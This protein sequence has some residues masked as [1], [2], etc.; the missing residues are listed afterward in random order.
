M[1]NNSTSTQKEAKQEMLNYIKAA[2]KHVN[3]L[4]ELIRN[5]NELNEELN[6]S[7]NARD[8]LKKIDNSILS[9][10]FIKYY[11]LYKKD[12]IDNQNVEKILKI[13]SSIH[14]K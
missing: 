2:R 10:M 12:Y 3:N 13:F 5:T 9:D 14:T 7:K 1:K 11:S 4:A 8:Y 6:E